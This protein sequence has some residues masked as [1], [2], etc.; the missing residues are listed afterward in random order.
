[1]P[2]PHESPLKSFWTSS[3]YQL[4][5]HRTTKDLPQKADVV[6]IGSGYTGAATAFFLL[7][8]P[9]ARPSTVILEARETCSGATGRNGGH[10]KPDPYLNVPRWVE[11]Y[12]REIAK[13]VADFEERQLWNVKKL[14]DRERIDCHFELTRAMD[15][16][17]EE[18]ESKRAV[19]AYQRLKA[20]G[21]EFSKDLQA[22]LE[23]KRAE[24]ISGVRGALAAFSFTAASIWSLQLVCHLLRRCLSW[25]ANLQTH[26]PV[27]AIS[28][29]QDE[30]GFY[31]IRTSRGSIQAKKIVVAT[32]A[33]TTAIL[34]EF[35]GKITPMRG[36]A[37][38]I[39]ISNPNT[40]VPRLNN[41]YSIRFGP[42]MYDYLI[43]RSD[44]SIVV[45]GAK[46]V[47][48]RND[49][50]WRSNSNDTELIP[51]VVE[52]FDDY[53]QR[54]FHGWEDTDAK[55]THIWTGAMGFSE[56]LLPWVGELPNRP[57]IFVA[58]GFTAHG[59][60]RIY[61]CAEALAQLVQGKIEHISESSAKLPPPMWITE[62]RMNTKPAL[63]REFMAGDRPEVVVKL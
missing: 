57:G 56:D 16:F 30:A 27:L 12:G 54:I 37:A 32:N 13:R 63:A 29:A 53:M 22:I 47:A 36:V 6:V 35:E 31:T 41:T 51:G 33:Y 40:E 60:T 14:V 7:E 2:L 45:G 34:P 10:I 39:A 9:E 62:A 43:P 1:M 58:A 11:M 48:L 19:A 50:Y 18:G 59:M 28:S 42:Q 20:S 55:V 44:G 25:G 38:R 17:V 5:N 23:P 24:R 4:R 15:V 61:G 46:Q 21:F 52:Y 49:K 26:T 8:D 3:P